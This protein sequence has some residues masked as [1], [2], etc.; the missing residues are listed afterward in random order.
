MSQTPKTLCSFASF[1]LLGAGC[2]AST[3]TFA[4]P[5]LPEFEFSGYG[6]SGIGSTAGG[7]DQACFKANGAPSKYRLGNECETYAEIALGANLYEQDDKTFFVNTMIGYSSDQSDD[8]EGTSGDDSDIALRQLNVQAT[9]VINGLPGATLWAGKRFYRRHDIVINDFFYWDVSGPG[10]GI[11]D[12]DLGIGKLSVAWL[13]NS[14]NLDED[15]PDAQ[16]R[17]SNDTVDIRWSDVPTNPGG[18]LVIGYD[19]GRATLTEAQDDY[20]DDRGIDYDDADKGH[21]VTL[22][23]KQEGWFGGFNKAAIQYATDG[24]INQ[25]NGNG[26]FGV[27]D[28]SDGISSGHM[29]RILDHGQVWLVPDKIDMLY[30]AVYEKQSFDDN[31]GR[32]WIS[33][34]IRPSYYWSDIMS[35]ALELGYDYIDP[36]DS[37]VAG[38]SDHHLGKLT[39]AQQWSAGRGAMAR[40]T[41][42]LFATYA[43]WDGD[44]LQANPNYSSTGES[45]RYIGASLAAD[46][47][48]DAIEIDDN[49]GL[50]FG[51]Q[52][53][54]WW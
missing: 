31:S 52:M 1:A 28:F 21:M 17:T 10:A 7:G 51:L 43:K 34:G 37:D 12:I 5:E 30:A 11:E 27:G 25:G 50:T 46:D 45:S 15:Y 4:A 54:A 23:H 36:E 42:R 14:N 35:T 13:R 16:N 6:R 38:Y 8:Y 2:F 48:T 53:E 40:P 39:I 29:W 47:T 44:A 19:Y 22:Q 33:A 41:I 32:T 26:R 3:F 20:L 18:T 24:I 49:D 9:N